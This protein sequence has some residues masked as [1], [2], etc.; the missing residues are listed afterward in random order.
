MWIGRRSGNG[1]RPR[2]KGGLT[3]GGEDGGDDFGEAWVAAIQAGRPSRAKGAMSIGDK[4]NVG[5]PIAQAGQVVV[6][7]CPCLRVESCE[8]RRPCAGFLRAALPDPCDPKTLIDPHR[9]GSGRVIVDLANLPESKLSARCA[10]LPPAGAEDHLIRCGGLR[11]IKHGKHSNVM[12]SDRV[13]FDILLSQRIKGQRQ[14]RTRCSIPHPQGETDFSIRRGKRDD[15]GGG[16]RLILM[17]RA[18]AGFFRAI[19]QSKGT[20][21]GRGEPVARDKLTAVFGDH[22]A[23]PG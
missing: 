8:D 14:G 16:A 13:F 3:L 18:I 21:S 1:R 11:W 23:H 7:R 2:S 4:I 22:H 19:R 5:I 6:F 17:G 12:G 10:P 20:E 15:I 9:Q